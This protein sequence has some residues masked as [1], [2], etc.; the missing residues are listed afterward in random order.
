MARI[1][2]ADERE[3]VV[4]RKPNRQEL[5]TRLRSFRGQLPDDFTF[6]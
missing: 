5:L 1:H 4:S 3:L 6:D 2:I